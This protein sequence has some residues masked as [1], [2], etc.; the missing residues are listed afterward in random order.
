MILKYKNEI[1][2]GENNMKNVVYTLWY[3]N[4]T[5]Y[6]PILEGIYSTQEKAQDAAQELK[7]LDYTVWI[8]ET[9]VQ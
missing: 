7:E 5:R 2:K 6:N 3:I 1:E 8:D 4:P 9:E